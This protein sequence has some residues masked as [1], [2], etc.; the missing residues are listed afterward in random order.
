VL[1]MREEIVLNTYACLKASPL[2]TYIQ[3]SSP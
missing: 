2:K 1:D 3:A